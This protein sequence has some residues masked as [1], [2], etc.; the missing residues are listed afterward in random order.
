ML[1]TPRYFYPIDYPRFA[2]A[3]KTPQTWGSVGEGRENVI[4]DNDDPIPLIAFNRLS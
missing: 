3:I 4:T 2:Q 1:Y